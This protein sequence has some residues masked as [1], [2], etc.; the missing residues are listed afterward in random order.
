MAGRI[1]D[2]P[3][4]TYHAVLKEN[5]RPPSKGG[6]TRAWHQHTLV[7]G[8]ERYSF[9]GLGAKKWVFAGDTVS[10]EWDWDS[11]K[12]YRNI[13]PDSVVT[14]NKHGETVVRGERGAKKWRTA[15]TRPPG[16]RSEWDD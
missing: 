5:S 16:R 11:L 4:E 9:L 3:V 7:I 2:Q 12:R 13:D 6:N 1:E 15:V 10:F 8:G 14:R